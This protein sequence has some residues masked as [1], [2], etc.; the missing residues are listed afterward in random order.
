MA[1]YEY[2]KVPLHWF[3]QDIIDQYKIMNLV[4]KDG[5]VYVKILCHYARQIFLCL[6]LIH[7]I[8]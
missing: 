2:I 5:F 3:P 1:R 7:I 4:D 6:N 8:N